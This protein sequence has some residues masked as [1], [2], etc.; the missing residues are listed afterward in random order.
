MFSNGK[1]SKNFKLYSG[2]AT[3]G[4]VAINP[5]KAELSKI[6]GTSVEK[7]P[8]YISKMKD[9]NVDQIRLDFIVAT[10]PN[11]N[12]GVNF[13]S[14]ISFFIGGAANYNKD[15]TKVK[16]I[17]KYGETAW[18]PGDLKVPEN[19]S[20]YNTEGMRV[21]FIGEE[22]L[23]NF[24]KTYMNIPV[25]SWKDTNGVTHTIDNPEEAEALLEKIPMYFKGDI[26]EIRDIIKMR[27]TNEIKVLFG[28]K[29]TDNNM[30]YQVAYTQ[31]FLKSSSKNYDRLEKDVND[32]QK[33]MAYPNT[34]FDIK[35]ISEYKDE[36]TQDFPENT[37]EVAPSPFFN[38]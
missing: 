8:E 14:K 17:N 4:I 22:E 33:A 27:P 12:N 24:I 3:V 30:Q 9:T 36:P 19:M 7:D 29:T 32:R 34:H 1:E 16:V 35:C 20:W 21:A 28:I 18:V 11:K 10:D 26:S 2:I 38:K 13:K 5:T 15:K 37:T 31:M 23:V 6:Y 25:R